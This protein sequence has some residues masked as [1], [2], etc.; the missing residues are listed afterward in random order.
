VTAHGSG[1]LRKGRCLPRACKKNVN[2]GGLN[3][4]R[5][6]A[7]AAVD[8]G[9]T[10]V[11]DAVVGRVAADGLGRDLGRQWCFAER[12]KMKQGLSLM[13]INFCCAFC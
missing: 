7:N 3:R 11:A 6:V 8:G 4:Y 10:V 9:A 12:K 5:A 2:D 13:L 1:V